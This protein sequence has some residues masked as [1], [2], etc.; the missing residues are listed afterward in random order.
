[1]ASDPRFAIDDEPQRRG[2]GCFF[3]GCLTLVVLSVVCLVL[4]FIAVRAGMN[5]LRG[6]INQY[7][8]DAPAQLPPL[9]VPA[10]DRKAIIDRVEEY[11]KLVE[12]NETLTD[13]QRTL[14]LTADEINVLIEDDER[15]LKGRARVEING[16]KL[17]G[18]IS[19]PLNDIPLMG[20]RY[21]NG[22]ATIVPQAVRGEL[23]IRLVDVEVKGQR[24]PQEVQ[25][26]LQ[27]ENIIPDNGQ[28]RR[29]RIERE[30]DSVEVVNGKLRIVFAKEPDP[31]AP[32]PDAKGPIERRPGEPAAT[33]ET[34][35]EE[36]KAAE[37]PS[38]EATSDESATPDEEKAKAP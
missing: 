3:Y 10:D 30:L 24:L 32:R 12:S 29:N 23:Q 8:A 11:R 15:D 18:E 33:D 25:D 5:F 22:R 7:T 28:N 36:P 21:L 35:S 20:G 17:Q 13:E 19:I 4:M 38:D 26:A 16:D 34:E 9:N 27:K 31:V 37:A 2:R 6:Q 1:M 14:E